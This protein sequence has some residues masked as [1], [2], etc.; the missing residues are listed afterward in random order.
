ML[1]WEH[2]TFTLPKYPFPE[3]SRRYP[4]DRPPCGIYTSSSDSCFVFISKVGPFQFGAPIHYLLG[5]SGI[6]QDMFVR[7]VIKVV[8][9]TELEEDSMS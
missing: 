2:F 7:I 1:K 5:G 9:V 8:C 6:G 3:T 4:E